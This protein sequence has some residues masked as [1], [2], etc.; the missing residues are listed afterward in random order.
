MC[1]LHC[2]YEDPP[3]R[4]SVSVSYLTSWELQ[5]A[6]D[7]SEDWATLKRHTNDTTIRDSG[8]V[9]HW[10]IDWD[11]RAREEDGRPRGFNKFRIRTDAVTTTGAGGGQAVCLVQGLELYGALTVTADNFSEEFF[12]SP[13]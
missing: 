2:Q 6:V 1:C 3:E 10:P 11:G 12:K 4:P 9:G 5:G 13:E 7:E 8:G